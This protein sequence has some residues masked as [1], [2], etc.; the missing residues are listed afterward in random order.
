MSAT[1]RIQA[2]LNALLDKSVIVRLTNGKQ[3]IGQLSSFEISP[4]L[5][6]LSSAKDN[7]NNSF[8][9]VIL[10]GSVIS[11]IILKAA[12]IFDAREFAEILQ[13]NLSLRPGDIKLYDDVGVITVM[14]KIRVTESGVEG[15]GPMA[16]RIYDLYND[17]ISK[18]K[19]G[20]NK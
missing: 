9:K 5:V 2:D 1:R 13:R 11:E 7:E 18:R 4:F 19:K 10:N 14:E 16:Q 6:S 12:P 17:Y 8:H 3:Y 15:T 20:D